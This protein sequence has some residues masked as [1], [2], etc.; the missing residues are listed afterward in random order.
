MDRPPP[1]AFGHRGGCGNPARMILAQL[2]RPPQAFG[3]RGGCGQSGISHP[4]L[5]PPPQAFGHRG[6]CGAHVSMV[7]L[8][9]GLRRLKPSDIAGAAARTATTPTL[10]GQPASSLRT[11]RGLR[12]RVLA[13]AEYQVLT[14][15]LTR[16]RDSGFASGCIPAEG[17]CASCCITTAARNT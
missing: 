9:R 1:Q 10:G 12:H 8:L 14:S 11:S 7:S 13:L 4:A 16:I 6:G 5:D 15:P 17:C 2:L 3:H